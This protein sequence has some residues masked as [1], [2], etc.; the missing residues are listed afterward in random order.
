MHIRRTE[1]QWK[2]KENVYHFFIVHFCCHNT[3]TSVLGIDATCNLC[4]LWTSDSCQLVHNVAG[5]RPV[6]LGPLLFQFTKDEFIFTR[7]ALEMIAL[8]PEITNIKK[9]G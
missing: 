7:F 8:D 1:T 5:N 6:F 3:E 9:I 4:N 2:I